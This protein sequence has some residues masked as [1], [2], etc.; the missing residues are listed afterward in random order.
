MNS[1]VLRYHL[2]RC[3]DDRW[4]QIKYQII[5][6]KGQSMKVKLRPF[7]ILSLIKIV[8]T[9]LVLLFVA[10]VFG[11]AIV[12]RN[13]LLCLVIIAVWPL[14]QILYR[15]YSRTIEVTQGKIRFTIDHEPTKF[16]DLP[17][18]ITEEFDLSKLKF[19]GVFSGMYILDAVKAPRG[20]GNQGEVDQLR[21]KEGVIKLPVGT[22]TTG[23]PMAFVFTDES[24]VLDDYLFSDLQKAALFRAIED[25]TKIQPS[26]AVNSAEINQSNSASLVQSGKMILVLAIG[27][28]I[29]FSLPML[30]G[31]IT[32][33]QV[34]WFT[35]DYLQTAYV[36][37]F[38]GAVLSWVVKMYA[39]NSE[40][41]DHNF[42][43]TLGFITLVLCVLFISISAV[44]FVLSLFI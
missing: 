12:Q 18:S 2:K 29:A 14:Y 11:Y 39:R 28:L 6:Q 41:K 25:Q 43:E 24:Y 42:G 19:Y 22:L 7:G 17:K 20:K 27:L 31:K 4:S 44:V 38:A 1:G 36:F 13:Y 30:Q 9:I 34:E 5:I 37:M 32:G 15:N 21:V 40:K 33:T 35:F 26:G 23:N 3:R 16:L 10:G 8:I